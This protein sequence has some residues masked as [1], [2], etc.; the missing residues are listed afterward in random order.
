[1]IQPW[2]LTFYHSSKEHNILHSDL[3]LQ[4]VHFSLNVIPIHRVGCWGFP[5]PFFF[6]SLS[7]SLS[8]SLSTK[9]LDRITFQPNNLP[10][11]LPAQ[12][13]SWL[14]SYQLPAFY[15]TSDDYV[16][17]RLTFALKVK[18]VSQMSIIFF[19]NLQNVIQK[20]LSAYHY[21]SSGFEQ[22]TQYII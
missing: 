16:S 11:L 12:K 8:L 9:S 22:L 4:R 18:I 21:F 2:M 6:F 15:C 17:K 5:R 14:F 1:M 3:L 19:N 10:K 7:L 20:S 13:I